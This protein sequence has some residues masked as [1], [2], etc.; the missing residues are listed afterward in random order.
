M[1][2]RP[3]HPK[4]APVEGWGGAP[5]PPLAV[6]YVLKMFPRFSET[7]ILNEI[8]ELERRGVRVVVFS[9]KVPNETVRQ[10]GVAAVRGTVHVIPPLRGRG[11]ATHA[12]CHLACFLRSP[13]RYLA[14]LLFMLQRGSRAARQ[15][16]AVAP[17]IARTARRAGIE[18]FHAHFA[19]GPARQA[20]FA[21]LLSG[22]PFSFTAHAKDLFWSGH[23][24]GNNN[25]LKKRVRLAAFVVTISEYNRRFIERLGFKVPRRRVVT[26]YNG[27]DL[28]HWDFRRPDGLPVPTAASEPPLLLAVGRLVEKKGFDVVIE[29]CG[30][31][32][33]RGVVAQCLIAGDGERRRHLEGLIRLH[34]LRGR[35]T[36][37]GSIP[38]DRLIEDLYARAAWLVVPSVVCADGDQDGIP[39]V[40]LEAMAVGLPVITTPVSGIGEAVLHERTGLLVPPGDAP[41]LADALARGLMDR[42][43]PGPLARNARRLV[44]R[45]FNLRNNSKVLIHLMTVSARGGA[46]WSETKLRERCGLDLEHPAAAEELG[47]EAATGN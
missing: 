27:L 25:K 11:W 41:A 8:L 39:T 35:I 33:R 36:L 30:L 45:R 20:K 40:I 26:V 10:P 17:Y 46:R 44:E 5:S 19:S 28:Q 2:E 16:F 31:M 42:A 3:Y 12:D 4:P 34:G 24:H 6:G 7:F 13:R 18:H 38:Q 22:I 21:S 9:M 14:T 23:S 15:K 29:A 32:Q 43:L 1:T 37:A 47:H